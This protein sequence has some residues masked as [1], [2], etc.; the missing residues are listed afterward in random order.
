MAE[1]RKVTQEELDDICKKHNIW[2]EDEESGERAVLENC[3]FDRLS[4]AGKQ[5]NAAVFRNC[6]FKLCDLTDAGMCFAEMKNIN[7]SGCDC[8]LLV[9]EEA[10]LRDVKFERC[11]L[12]STVFTHSSFRNI[13]F[14]N[15]EREGMSMD[16]CYE[17]PEVEIIRIEPDK[18][19]TMSKK[20][21][22][23]LQGC[24]GDLQEWAD[25]I[26]S[27][28]IEDDILKNDSMF[29]KLYAFEHEGHTCLLFPFEGVDLDI[30]KL[31]MWRLQTHDIFG[32]TWLSDYVPNRLGGFVQE[33][34]DKPMCPIIGADSN[35]FNVMGMASKTLK[36]SG[37]ADQAKEMCDRVT[38]S[39]DYNKALAII[40]EYVE[41]CSEEDMTEL[42]ETGMNF[43]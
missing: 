30:G 40:M 2:N 23:V 12:R 13:H 3:I 18:L 17:L 37:M 20:E 28:L 8:H 22:L 24:G 7:F 9:A 38:Q 6:D 10:A 14:D 21:G 35:I 4:F 29:N 32:G 41:P 11:D 42:E 5:F 31:A 34:R 25:R 26:N 33:Q 36:R 27:E 1:K 43:G 19:R 39:G 15:C 16:K